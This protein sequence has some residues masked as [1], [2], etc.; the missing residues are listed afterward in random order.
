[1]LSAWVLI[2]HTIGKYPGSSLDHLC[3]PVAPTF[4]DQSGYYHGKKKICIPYLCCNSMFSFVPE[5]DLGEP[6]ASDWSDHGLADAISN[7]RTPSTT[8]ITNSLT[9]IRLQCQRV[10]EDSSRLE[11]LS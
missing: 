4:F 3:E 1:M 10:S 9:Q 5:V 6:R 8:T 7:S 2:A 11:Y